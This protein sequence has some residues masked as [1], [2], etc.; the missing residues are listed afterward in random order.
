MAVQKLQLAAPATTGNNTHAGVAP[1]GPVHIGADLSRVALELE[2]TVAGA[3]PTL[4]YKL[5][6]ANDDPSVA[7]GAADWFDLILDPSDS[8]T[9]AASFVKTAVGVY[10]AY[11]RSHRFAR[12]YRLVTSAN[13]NVT[14]EAEL[15]V[16]I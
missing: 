9:G 10:V 16:D 11:L 15:Y 7:D 5:Q 4:T 12:R 13:T 1:S 14:Y 6:G 8:D 3:T 2:I